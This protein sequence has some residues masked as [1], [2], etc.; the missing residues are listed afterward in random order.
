MSAQTGKARTSDPGTDPSAPVIVKMGGGGGGL[1][2]GNDTPLTSPPVIIESPNMP[3]VELVPGQTWELSKSN[4]PGRIHG[5]AINEE[6]T[7]TITPSDELASVRIEFGGAQLLLMESRAG[8]DIVLVIASVGAAFSSSENWRS[9][10][11]NN[12][13]AITGVVLMQGTEV[14]KKHDFL[15]DHSVTLTIDF[16]TTVQ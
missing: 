11:A 6:P 13:P 5:L 14:K 1:E 15:I 9:A 12:F 3:F 16:Q 7:H 2:Y 10:S 8:E 4:S